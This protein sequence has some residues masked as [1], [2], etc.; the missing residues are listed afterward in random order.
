MSQW[1]A[2]G[3][4]V[5]RS[6]TSRRSLHVYSIFSSDAVHRR[7]LRETTSHCMV[8]VAA[9]G[10]SMLAKLSESNLTGNQTV[11]LLIQVVSL[12]ESLGIWACLSMG[13][14]GVEELLQLWPEE[15]VLLIIPLSSVHTQALLLVC[16]GVTDFK[17]EALVSRS[18]EH[19]IAHLVLCDNFYKSF[20][21]W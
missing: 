14:P 4:L 20:W 18:F 9:T 7:A 10:K 17:I 6:S 21:N 13:C 8:I 19:C 5:I 3:R 2:L 11:V 16:N 15:A 12:T 1:G